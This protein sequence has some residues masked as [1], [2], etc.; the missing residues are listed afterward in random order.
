[1]ASQMVKR[2]LGICREEGLQVA[3]QPRADLLGAALRRG[4]VSGCGLLMGVCRVE[5]LQALTHPCNR[6]L[7]A[8]LPART[9][10]RFFWPA[11]VVCSWRSVLSSS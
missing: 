10:L 2:L 1:M 11:A 9:R 5:G 8:A 3:T 6:L 4:R 7:W